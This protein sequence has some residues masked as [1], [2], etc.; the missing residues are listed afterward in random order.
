MLLF[1][2]VV[3]AVTVLIL[4][5]FLGKML[6]YVTCIF[7]FYVAGTVIFSGIARAMKKAARA[8]WKNHHDWFLVA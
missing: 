2:I 3:F 8:P 4:G 1:S 5:S 6:F 7:A